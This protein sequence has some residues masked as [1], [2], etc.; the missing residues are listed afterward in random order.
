MPTRRA[1]PR[2]ARAQVFFSQ[3]LYSDYEIKNRTVQILFSLTFALSCS[4]F[5]L[6][7]FE[8]LDVLQRSTRWVHWKVDL[9]LMLLLLIFVLPFFIFRLL[10]IKIFRTR[11]YAALASVVLMAAFLLCFYKIGDPFPIVS[12]REH[13]LLSIEH[14][15]SRIGVIGVTSMAIL[16]GFGA[17]NAPYEN[18]A[19]FLRVVDDSHLARVEK[20]MLMLLEHLLLKKKRL[21]IVRVEVKRLYGGHHPPEAKATLLTKLWS[22]M[23]LAVPN[24][25][26]LLQEEA[27]KL[28]GEIEALEEHRRQQFT[29][30][31]ELH[32]G[33]NRLERSKTCKGR[34][35][36]FL[37]YLFSIYCIYKVRSPS[38]ARRPLTP[39]CPARPARPARPC[40]QM[41]MASINIIF[42]R[43]GK[44]DPVSRALEI[45]LMYFL[46]LK[47]DVRF[48]CARPPA[49]PS[50]VDLLADGRPLAA[51]VDARVVLAR[52]R[53]RG[54]AN[55]WASHL[56]HETF[57]RV[58]IGYHVQ[59]HDPRP[60]RA[61]GHVFHILVVAHAHESA[62]RVPPHRHG[63]AWRH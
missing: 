13:G 6:I 25:A 47:I 54:H 60:G 35:F 55:A 53:D 38:A 20:D 50:P 5:Q 41:V 63:G 3:R 17:V 16:S 22:S 10:T 42:Q 59:R 19:Y 31:H 51:Q 30:M 14:G 2:P 44:T 48:W 23:S 37:G 57:P 27:Q 12:K 40:A 58:V 1:R 29:S 18:L 11:R 9:Y 8:I 62:A 28:R 45:L 52:G 43:V 46:D 15:V 21:L 49:S 36:N 56:H 39:P 34:F 4:M 33:R 26:R 32:Y 7:I 61:H 24:E